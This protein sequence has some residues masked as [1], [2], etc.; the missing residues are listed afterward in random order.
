[1]P[2]CLPFEVEPN[3][4]HQALVKLEEKYEVFIVTQNVDDLHESGLEFLKV[5]IDVS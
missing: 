1:M 4:G 5:P 3:A 2:M